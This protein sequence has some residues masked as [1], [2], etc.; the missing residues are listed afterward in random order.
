MG[1]G[2]VKIAG[3][4]TEFFLTIDDS[5]VL[6]A[7]VSKKF[8]LCGFRTQSGA[9]CVISYDTRNRDVSII[10]IGY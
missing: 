4:E 1:A 7:T 6:R 10:F 8:T 2:L 3:V 9:L 5:G